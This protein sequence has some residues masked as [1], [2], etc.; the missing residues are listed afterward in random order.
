MN[1]GGD[2]LQA[3]AFLFGIIKHSL[4][5]TARNSQRSEV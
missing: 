4:N 3:Q 1:A 2:Q 5:T